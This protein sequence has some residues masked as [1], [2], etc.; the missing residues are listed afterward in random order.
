M[1]S[2][3][4]T[5]LESTVGKMLG[6]KR[7]QLVLVSGVFVA[8]LGVALAVAAAWPA[9]GERVTGAPVTS[10]WPL[11]ALG[12]ALLVIGGLGVLASWAMDALVKERKKRIDKAL[13]EVE[14]ADPS[15]RFALKSMRFPHGTRDMNTWLV[16]A[17]NGRYY[18]HRLPISRSTGLVTDG[19]PV[20]VGNDSEKGSEFD[21]WLCVVK[22]TDAQRDLERYAERSR[23]EYDW[24]GIESV[25]WPAACTQE[26]F[27]ATLVRQ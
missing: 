27:R 15:Q 23:E 21:V 14:W 6:M 9:L 4:S 22:D 17:S 11:V 3:L 10:V 12:V 2:T 25:D 13:A 19:I 20:H 18:P 1:N 26:L 24:S 16:V 8:L 7:A 5:F